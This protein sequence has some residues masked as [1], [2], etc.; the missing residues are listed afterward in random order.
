VALP[1]RLDVEVDGQRAVAGKAEQRSFG[2]RAAGMLEHAGNSDAA[3]AAARLGGAA[4]RFEMFVI[5]QLQCALQHRR[6]VAAVIRRA[7]GGFVRHRRRGNEI[8]PAQF[9]RIDAGDARGFLDQ[10]LK[11][12]I[13]L[14]PPG[15]A[16]RRGRQ[17]VG[18][19]A[20][21]ADVDVANVVHARQAARETQSRDRRAHGADIGAE[22][23]RIAYAQRQKAPLVV[24]RELGFRVNIARLIIAEESFGA[25]RHPMDRASEFFGAD[26]QRDVFRISA[27]FQPEG[28]ADVVG[29][30]LQPRRRNFHDR[31]EV[32][33][34][35]AGALR[36]HAQ[37]KSIAFGDV[38]RR[39]AA[40]LHRGHR[41]AL[42]DQRDTGDK[43]C[44]GE[45][46]VDFARIGLRIGGWSGPVDGEIGAG[47]RP[48]LRR[49]GGER[50]ARI[51]D[52][53]KRF[54]ID[55]DKLGG[56][57]RR[58][59]AVGDNHRHALA[60]VAHPLG[61]ERRAVRHDQRLA[62]APRQRRMAANAADIAHVLAGENSDNARALRRRLG[63]Y[64]SDAGKGMRRAYE[65][66]V[67]LIGQLHVGHE[68]AVAAN[69][70]IVFEARLVGRSTIR[71]CIHDLS[72]NTLLW[73][74]R[75]LYKRNCRALK[76]LSP[77]PGC[78][79]SAKR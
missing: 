23:G 79:A 42:V 37:N 11:H 6:K 64:G 56:V 43:F 55:G 62:A 9:Y 14:R 67:G 50:R 10:P 58:G 40:R 13:R 33:P 41:H 76:E 24:E 16:I 47:F 73:G 77:V 38:L 27:G 15:A 68:A 71:F 31:G 69:E 57:L 66:G 5:R 8:A 20:T 48:E 60:D 63:V 74:G 78:L 35:D 22:V 1:R 26:Q 30:H 21:H 32:V 39:G 28:A 52:W 17:R 29:Q 45:Y 25:A 72:R 61:G 19:G 59:G 4:A 53:G 7:D 3:M 65:T 34:H 75:A 54:I 51:H 36:A 12:V 70:S 46:R 44:L 18:E 49:A 2:R